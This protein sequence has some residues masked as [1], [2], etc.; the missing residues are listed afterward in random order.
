MVSS[1]P[2]NSVLP[3]VLLTE[4]RA[5]KSARWNVGALSSVPL[6]DSSGAS[7][8]LIVVGASVPSRIASTVSRLRSPS[9]CAI[10]ARCVLLF[11]LLRVTSTSVVRLVGA[12]ISAV[13]SAWL[14]GTSTGAG[15]AEPAG[16][17][18][19]GAGSVLPGSGAGSVPGSG[20]GGGGGGGGAT[21]TG[22]GGGAPTEMAKV[23]EPMPPP[24]A[25]AT[26]KTKPSSVTAP[27]CTYAIR[28]ASTSACVKVPF[29]ASAAPPW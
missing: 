26:V 19:D 6:T 3:S 20:G 24:P 15:G 23:V 7:P 13:S 12:P 8:T 10:C 17:S 28:P 18:S 2:T 4:S 16:V 29:T 21:T 9:M 5:P 27:P 1:S 22:G 11:A 25:S 14:T